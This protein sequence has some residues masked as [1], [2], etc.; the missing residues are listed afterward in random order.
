MKR[1][2][3]V[4][5]GSCYL[6]K[7]KNQ[8]MNG[9]DAMFVCEEVMIAGVADGVG[10]WAR[11]GI[12]PGEYARELMAKAEE[13]L[14]QLE[15]FDVL[16]EA[17]HGTTSPGASTACIVALHDIPHQKLT[18]VNVG[19]S[20]FMVV[21]NG[22]TIFKSSIQQHRFNTTYSLGQNNQRQDDFKKAQVIEVAVEADD[23]VVL[24]TDGLFDNVFSQEI[25]DLIRNKINLI[26]KP[27]KLATKIA[28][29][30][31]EYS[32]RKF[33]VTPYSEAKSE[34]VKTSKGGKRDDI[35]VV[36]KN[37]KRKMKRVLKMEAGWSYL[38]KPKKQRKN[39]DD[40][41][42]VCEE[43]MIAGVA[44]GVGG[45]AKEG[46]DP[47]EYARELMERTEL[48]KQQHLE[49]FV[50]LSEAYHGA[51][52]AGAS[53]AC[54]VA[55][56]DTANQKLT[57]HAVN[58][59]DSGFII[60]RNGKTV[61]KSTVQQH[62]FNIPFSLGQ[63]SK[64]SDDFTRAQLIEVAVKT[65][66]IVVLGT[67]GLFD[68]VFSHEIEDLIRNKKKLIAEPKKLATEIAKMAK[69]FSK[70]WSKVTPYSIAKSKDGKISIGGK[71]D[72]IT[73]VVLN[74]VASDE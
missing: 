5:A 68:N 23:I 61:F 24:G 21:R 10:G 46:I 9:D 48:V 13:A 18:A 69:G 58:V 67:D 49:P 30:A 19:D 60:L 12:D 33:K 3:K 53:T 52:A 37:K 62:R 41:M 36:K 25:E 34:A 20:G 2:L 15:P 55:L 54:I 27:E 44:D 16:S 35:T 45:W 70:E 74:I 31:E 8:R 6:P 66:D 28:K 26:A 64:R 47:G 39:G 72:D 22:Y 63:N 4:K 65:G 14:L 57:V 71:Q 32:K 38:P 43:L 40:A 50:V 7:P 73:V 56:H 17:Y 1:T 51:T 11:E 29:M 42:F 59:G